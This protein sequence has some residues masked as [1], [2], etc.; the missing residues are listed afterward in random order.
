MFSTSIPFV[1]F[2]YFRVPYTVVADLPAERLPARHPLRGGG[3][4]RVACGAPSATMFW[5]LVG[6]AMAAAPAAA[7]PTTAYWLGSVPIHCRLIPDDVMVQWLAELGSGWRR[8]TVVR[9]RHGHGVAA[10]WN[11]E[12]GNVVLPFDPDEAI[13]NCWSEAYRDAGRRRPVA[14]LRRL[15]VRSYY[16]LRPAMPRA[17]QLR[18][19]RAL[20]RV[21]A[22][23]RFPRWPLE[24]SL[25]DLYAFLFEQIADLTQT[26]VPWL[27][28][29]PRGATWALVLTHDVETE[30]GYGRLDVLRRAELDAGCRSSWNFVPLRYQVEDRLVRQLT[31]EGFE[32]GVHGLYH[33][34]RDLESE[35]VLS[36]RLPRIREYAQRWGATGFRSPATHRR[37][38][39]MPRLGFEYDSSYPD[40]DPFE[41]QPGGCCSWLPYFNQNLV[42]LPITLPQD[43]TLFAILGQSNE[44]AW[45]AKANHIRRAGGMSL[46]LTHPDYM[47]ED[48]YV[49]AYRRFL[50]AFRTD[51]AAWRALPREVSAWWRRRA[52]SRLVRATNGWTIDGPAAADGAVVFATGR[53]GK[54]Q[55]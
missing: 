34:G 24:T 37:W 17:A 36:Q 30:L 16:R 35:T 11:D 25:H 42:E 44:G 3:R 53:R 26:P 31:D 47:I 21:Q 9:D 32:V 55:P 27:A 52:A 54:G 38:E 28:P 33:D 1:F 48:R 14:Q 23:T 51:P 41:P 46:L 6:R 5:P 2:D 4:L 15:A 7:L 50:D 13:Q 40:T 20:T 49:A 10:V 29:W 45:L 12:H 18:L 8:Q 19:R 22:R 43:H 39:W